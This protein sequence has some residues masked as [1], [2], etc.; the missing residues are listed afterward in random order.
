MAA[1]KEEAQTTTDYIVS[2][3]PIIDDRLYEVEQKPVY[4]NWQEAGFMFVVKKKDEDG[5]INNKV[6]ELKLK[7][8]IGDATDDDKADLKLLTA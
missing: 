6:K 7:I 1:P 2:A 3:L 8:A 4:N 5:I